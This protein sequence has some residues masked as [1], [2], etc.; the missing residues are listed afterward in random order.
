M[1]LFTKTVVT[2]LIRKSNSLPAITL[3]IRK[4]NFLVL[5]YALVDTNIVV[6]LVAIGGNV[7]TDIVVNL[8]A[9]GESDF[10]TLGA[11]VWL[12]NRS[13][14]GLTNP[15]LARAQDFYLIVSS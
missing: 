3:L 14:P 11:T 7:V 12:A 13:L 4:S 15:H 5:S 8:V 10:E 9:I 2:L 6:E 1:H